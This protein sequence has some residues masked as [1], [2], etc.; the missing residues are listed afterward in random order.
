MVFSVFD[1]YCDQAD[2]G[3]RRARRIVDGHGGLLTAFI[4]VM[5][6]GCWTASSSTIGFTW[7]VSRLLTCTP[8]AFS[9]RLRSWTQRV[10]GT[11]VR[12]CPSYR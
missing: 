7:Q 6:L 1:A 3:C 4:L 11:R 5:V 2:I 8:A 12:V 10:S 9:R